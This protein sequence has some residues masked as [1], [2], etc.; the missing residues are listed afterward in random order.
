MYTG[1]YEPLSRLLLIGHLLQHLL[2]GEAREYH[3]YRIE[4][5]LYNTSPGNN[6]G[7]DVILLARYDD[8]QTAW[9]NEWQVRARLLRT[10]QGLTTAARALHALG[11][12]AVLATHDQARCQLVDQP[13]R[14]LL[15]DKEEET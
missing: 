2:L 13:V 6:A 15:N 7:A 9:V 12:D 11:F 1:T 5:V 4:R 3:G 10:P 14:A 8:A